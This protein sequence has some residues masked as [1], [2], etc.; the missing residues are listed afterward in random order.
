MVNAS[1]DEKTVRFDDLE[2]I[3]LFLRIRIQEQNS[4]VPFFFKFSLLFFFHISVSKWGGSGV[5]QSLDKV[6]D[7]LKSLPRSV[8]GHKVATS[9]DGQVVQI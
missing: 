5:G 9:P 4:S 7:H 6:V 1:E 8:L 2:E 3:V